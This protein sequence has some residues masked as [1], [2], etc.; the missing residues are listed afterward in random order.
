[1]DHEPDLGL[2]ASK[3]EYDET[4]DLIL[5][6]QPAPFE[7]SSLFNGE[8]RYK[9]PKWW[10]FFKVC[11]PFFVTPNFVSSFLH[12]FVISTVSLRFLSSFG[13]ISG[14]FFV[15]FYGSLQFLFLFGLCFLFLRYFVSLKF[16]RFSVS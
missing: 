13:Y 14:N 3:R 12:V 15:I 1:M 5:D 10:S 6:Q 16:I 7:F 8:W 9:I 11:S 2:R 4:T